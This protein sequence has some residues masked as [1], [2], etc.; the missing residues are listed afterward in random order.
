[1][2]KGRD[3]EK[4]KVNAGTKGDGEETETLEL[5]EREFITSIPG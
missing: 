4:H 2:Q 3:T 5:R 1:M